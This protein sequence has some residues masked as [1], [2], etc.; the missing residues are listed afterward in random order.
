MNAVKYKRWHEII[1]RITDKTKKTVMAEVGVW[2]GVMISKLLPFLPNLEWYGVDTWA[3]PESGSSYA[4][5]G[6]EI[7][8]KPSEEFMSAFH[9]VV[10]IVSPYKG[11]VHIVHMDSVLAAQSFQ[12]ATFD[13]VFIDA[14]HSYEGCLR[15]IRAWLPKVKP[16]GLIC[17]HDYANKKGDVKSA[18]DESFP[19]VQLGADHTWFY[20]LPEV[21]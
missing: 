9:E 3:P 8:E 18:V 13:I 10:R 19:K 21:A 12:D 5:S 17:G 14:D 4:S 15:D 2:R 11:R 1:H 16:G 7:A 20:R 6:A